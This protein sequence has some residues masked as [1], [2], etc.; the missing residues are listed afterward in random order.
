MRKVCTKC[1]LKK[2][3]LE[4]GPDNR[5]KSGKQSRCK[6]CGNEYRKKY[7]IR[8][9]EECIVS[10]RNYRKTK[11][12]KK[13]KKEYLKKN[14]DRILKYSKEYNF[15]NKEKRNSKLKK[16]RKTNIRFCL[17]NGL[18]RSI[19]T[20]LKGNKAGRHWETLVNFTLVDLINH[21]EKQFTPEMNFDNYG[22][23]WHIDHIIPKSWFIYKTPE[24][25]GFKMC[26]DL[27]N[28]QPLEKHKNMFKKNRL[29]YIPYNNET[30]IF[31]FKK[32]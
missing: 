4:F 13:W 22:S 14:K 31:K 11:K 23:Y 24:D 28:L 10:G 20:A 9:K 2:E 1:G 32:K 7:Y 5:T 15:K 8:N 26:W 18:S 30:S 17:N 3:Y 21:L 27:D 6:Q 29:L 19:A 12:H 16:I 25:I